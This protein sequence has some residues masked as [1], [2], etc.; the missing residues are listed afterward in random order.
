ML[1]SKE[2]NEGKQCIDGTPSLGRPG[3][4]TPGQRRTGEDALRR[5]RPGAVAA[6]ALI[7]A[8]AR[9]AEWQRGARGDSGDS[10]E[11]EEVWSSIS[12]FLGD[13]VSWVKIKPG[14]RRL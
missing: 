8:C 12:F 10:G 11:A 9:A 13:Q 14:D 5:R 6:T 3:G 1:D 7:S 4:N 2:K